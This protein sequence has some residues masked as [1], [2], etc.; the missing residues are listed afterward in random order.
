MWA[1]S[2]RMRLVDIIV[3]VFFF[4]KNDILMVTPFRII[5]IHFVLMFF[6]NDVLSKEPL[7]TLLVTILAFIHI[8]AI[9]AVMVCFMVVRLLLMLVILIL[10]LVLLI[11]LTELLK[12]GD[13]EVLCLVDG[14]MIKHVFFFIVF[15]LRSFLFLLGLLILCFSSDFIDSNGAHISID[16]RHALLLVVTFLAIANE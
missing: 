1:P 7:I 11:I 12:S 16:E 6:C 9:V 4:I 14:W 15:E 8:S 5:L 2:F 10:I 13:V 3:K